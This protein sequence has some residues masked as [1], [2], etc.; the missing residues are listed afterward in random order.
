MSSYGVVLIT[1]S[2]ADEAERIA[3]GLLEKKLAAC[4]NIV[5]GLRSLYWWQGKLED[6]SEVLL[7]VKTRRELFTELVAAVKALHS[8]TVPEVV[9]LPIVEGSGEYLQWIDGSTRQS[10]QAAS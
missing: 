9:M 1:A 7:L 2:N 4:C 3:R 8:Y 6:S 10:G 5:P